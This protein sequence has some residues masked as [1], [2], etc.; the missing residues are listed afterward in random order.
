MEDENLGGFRIENAMPAPT[1]KA[2][3]REVRWYSLIDIET[4]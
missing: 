2:A 3:R 4:Y 1:L